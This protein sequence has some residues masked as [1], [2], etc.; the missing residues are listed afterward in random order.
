MLRARLQQRHP[1]I[2]AVLHRRATV[3]YAE[4][5][6]PGEA[7]DQA[8]TGQA[9]EYAAPLIEQSFPTHWQR[10]ELTTLRRWLDALPEQLVLSKPLL[11]VYSAGVLYFTGQIDVAKRRLAA[12]DTALSL[13]ADTPARRVAAGYSAGLRTILASQAGDI[14]GTIASANTAL[15]LLAEDD[16]FM[17]AGVTHALGLARRLN[18][19]VAQAEPILTSAA[20]MARSSG[21]ILLTITA[22]CNIAAVHV[23]QGHLR[24]A[25]AIYHEALAFPD[26]SPSLPVLGAAHVGMADILGERNELAAARE[27]LARGNALARQGLISPCSARAQ[28]WNYTCSLPWATTRVCARHYRRPISLP[29]NTHSRRSLGRS[30]RTAPT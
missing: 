6:M 29:T 24:D 27:H 23:A 1:G 13:V 21:N 18:G 22:L 12:T 10:G 3:W 2:V 20:A 5:G 4:H 19:D 28:S 8:L 30:R 9:W 7:I 26:V 16:L 14:A 17:F 15:A 25:L 11:G